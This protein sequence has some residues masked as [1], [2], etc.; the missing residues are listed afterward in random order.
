MIAVAQIS[1]T[2]STKLSAA[3]RRKQL[4]DCEQAIDKGGRMMVEG[5]RRVRERKLY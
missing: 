1:R 3:E 5:F 2:D 4:T